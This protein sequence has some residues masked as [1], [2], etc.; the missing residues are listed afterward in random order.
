MQS[1]RLL[2]R[3]FTSSAGSALSMAFWNTTLKAYQ[4]D[5]KR[6]Y[7]HTRY[8]LIVTDFGPSKIRDLNHIRS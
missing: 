4:E 7:Q 6:L 1:I 5:K 3:N 2:T 8:A